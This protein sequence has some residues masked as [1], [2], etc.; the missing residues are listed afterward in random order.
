MSKKYLARQLVLLLKFTF[1]FIMV[2]NI[3]LMEVNFQLYVASSVDASEDNTLIPRV[4]VRKREGKSRRREGWQ[5]TASLWAGLTMIIRIALLSGK[6]ASGKFQ[7]SLRCY[8]HHL[9]YL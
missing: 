7:A 6:K 9:V 5:Y 4:K 1:Y 3:D 2:T 8:F